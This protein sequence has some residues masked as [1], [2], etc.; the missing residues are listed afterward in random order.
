[1]PSSPL[2]LHF[3][4]FALFIVMRMYL[5]LCMHVS[6]GAHSSQRHQIPVELELQ[7]VVSCNVGAGNGTWVVYS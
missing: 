6:T 1:M 2:I 4:V 5:F 7:V 3:C